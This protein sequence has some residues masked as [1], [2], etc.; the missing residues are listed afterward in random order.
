MTVLVGWPLERKVNALREPR[1]QAVDAFLTS[2]PAD[3][4]AT[5]TAALEAKGEFGLWHGLSL[6]LNF[7]TVALVT[8]AMALAA[9]LPENDG[10][11]TIRR[12]PPASA[13]A[14]RPAEAHT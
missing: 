1:Y 10:P 2:A 13:L 14:E 9:R 11:E 7:G 4:E 6:L 3:A 12:E 5:R 8:A